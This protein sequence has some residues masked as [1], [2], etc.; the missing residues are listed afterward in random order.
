M[1]FGCAPSST[2][3]D[4]N[5]LDARGP[6]RVQN[7]F[8]VPAQVLPPDNVRSIQLYRNGNFNAPPLIKLDDGEKLTL[9]FDYLGTDAKQFRVDIKHFTP[10]WKPSNLL[11]NFYQKG[12]FQDY[13]SEAVVSR[14][15]KPAY[16][17]FRYSLPNKNLGFSVSGNYMLTV[18]DYNSGDALFSLPFLVYEDKGKLSSS[19]EKLFTRQG[20][21]HVHHQPFSRYTIPK[22]VEMPQFDLSYYYV[23]NQF[24]GRTQKV[25]IYDHAT[26]GQ[27]Q[28]HL[29]RQEAFVGDYGFKTL[30]LRDMSKL[31][32]RIRDYQP[33]YTPPRVIL[34]RDVQDLDAPPPS[35]PGTTFGRP[36]SDRFSG[37]ADV[38][39]SLEPSARLN[40]SDQVY[41]V[42]DFTG[43]A[44]RAE[45][46]MRYD[47]TEA[48]WKGRAM[49]KEGRYAYKYVTL[50]N[51]RIDDLRLDN[52]F[53]LTRQQYVTLVYF[54]DPEMHYQ[55][56]LQAD[57]G[58]VN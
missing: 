51:G 16:T 50:S 53:T 3:N 11:S 25:D 7:P 40:A 4:R 27:V 45:N 23:Q 49:I 9:E 13:I 29:S 15:Q 32:R 35:A 37:Y 52:M 1:A 55:R 26:Q 28:F 38:Q 5:S 39:F 18:Y 57:V 42:G 24:W 19:V 41:L 14:N 47:S 22:F 33:E 17:H 21:F 46:R 20:T 48:L 10:D 30:D 34:Q 8:T 6:V 44:L 2:Q 36:K 12:M 31:G 58:Y 54:E 56:L 43:W